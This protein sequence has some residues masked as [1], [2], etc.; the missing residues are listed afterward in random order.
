MLPAATTTA[1]TLLAE[2]EARAQ[3]N[4]PPDYATNRAHLLRQFAP[5]YAVLLNHEADVNVDEDD[6]RAV[7]RHASSLRAGSAGTSGPGRALRAAQQAAAAAQALHLGPEPTGPATMALLAII[8]HPTA[9]LEMDELTLITEYFQNTLGDQQTE[10]I[11][12]HGLQAGLPTELWVG[13]LATY[14]PRPLL[15]AP[16]CLLQLAPQEI[17]AA[18]GRDFYFGV[19]ARLFV[20]RGRVAGSL[21]QHHFSLSQHRTGRLLAALAAAGI[22]AP[23]S[24]GSGWRLVVT[25]EAGLEGV[26]GDYG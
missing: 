3:P 11:F 19:A 9:E 26:L 7:L 17:D 16:V 21:L 25:D 5:M 24:E 2:W 4:R 23:A 8:S 22:I 1:E 18:T 13:L 6:A 15:P 10:V 20:Q 12:G 14:C